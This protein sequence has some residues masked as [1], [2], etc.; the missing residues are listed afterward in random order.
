MKKT[1]RQTLGQHFLKDNKA[2]RKIVH[3]I[4]PQPE[5]ILIEIGPGKGALTR[6]LTQRAGKVIA[7]EKDAR[8]ATLLKESAPTNLQVLEDDILKISFQ[9]VLPPTTPF[10]LVGNLPYSISS[11]I[12]FRVMEEQSFFSECHFLL[13]KEV[14]ERVCASAGSKAYAPLSIY[15]YIFFSPSLHF[16]LSPAAFYPP[17]KVNSA[18]MSLKKR[19]DPLFSLSNSQEFLRFLKTSFRH[20][21][22]TLYNNLLLANISASEIKEAFLACKIESQLRP[23][24]IP[25]EQFVSLYEHVIARSKTTRPSFIS[26]KAK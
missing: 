1:R 15:F 25:I 5:E 17:P 11:M 26:A 2:L 24:Q 18:F 4:D 14:A 23:E 21:R 7:I 16:S 6:L 10:K 8:L 22:K 19:Q 3:I 12:L 13:Q 20:R 9:K